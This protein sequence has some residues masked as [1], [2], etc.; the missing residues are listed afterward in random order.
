MR[1]KTKFGKGTRPS[2]TPKKRT[3]VETIK[4]FAKVTEVPT[5]KVLQ[6]PTISVAGWRRIPSVRLRAKQFHQGRMVRV[7]VYSACAPS[8]SPRL[9]EMAQ[10]RDK[11]ETEKLCKDDVL[12]LITPRRRR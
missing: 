2:P 4:R 8:W 12:K 10:I 7:F 1:V 5:D 9:I 3:R 6:D 11:I